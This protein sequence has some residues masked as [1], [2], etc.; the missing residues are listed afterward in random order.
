MVLL[1]QWTPWRT[2]C[3]YISI[4]R[5]WIIYYSGKIIKLSTGMHIDIIERVNHVFPSTR[6]FGLRQGDYSLCCACPTHSMGAMGLRVIYR[7][8]GVQIQSYF[9]LCIALKHLIWNISVFSFL[10]WICIYMMSKI[11]YLNMFCVKKL[12]SDGT[13]YS[14]RCRKK[15]Q[16]PPWPKH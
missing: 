10:H 11:H 12:I 8:A 4:E 9:Q 1:K 3:K 7:P 15:R 13:P 5:Y 2:I 16:D 6:V 14:W